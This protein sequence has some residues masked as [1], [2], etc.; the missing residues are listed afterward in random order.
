[1]GDSPPPME[2]VHQPRFTTAFQPRQ[3]LLLPRLG[4]Y[5]SY[6][7]KHNNNHDKLKKRI[8]PSLKQGSLLLLFPSFFLLS[9]FQQ[10]TVDSKNVCFA[11]LGPKKCKTHVLWNSHMDQ[12]SLSW[13]EAFFICR[14]MKL[15]FLSLLFLF[16]SLLLKSCRGRYPLCPQCLAKSVSWVSGAPIPGQLQSFL[17]RLSD[18][19]FYTSV[20]SDETETS[21]QRHIHPAMDIPSM[22]VSSCPV[23]PLT[24][25]AS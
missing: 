22:C 8:L 20:L 18:C 13:Y 16:L 14:G 25:P 17:D 4:I 21:N 2:G 7:E 12:N 15:N 5:F 19:P 11:L 9:F 10:W 3:K 23:P 6:Y 24:S 1:M